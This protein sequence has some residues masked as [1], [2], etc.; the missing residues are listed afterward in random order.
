[1]NIYTLKICYGIKANYNFGNLKIAGVRSLSYQGPYHGVTALMSVHD[2][3][4]SVD[5]AS[6][7]NI[8]VGSGVSD[9]VNFLQIGWMVN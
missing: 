4:I 8:Y 1:M 9:K 2:L 3:N 5:Q 7:A 6:Y